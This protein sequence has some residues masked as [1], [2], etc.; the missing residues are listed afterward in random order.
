MTRSPAPPSQ[1]P[2]SGHGATGHLCGSRCPHHRAIPVGSGWGEEPLDHLGYRRDDRADR[3]PYLAALR[4]RVLIYDGGTGTELFKYQLTTA[5]YGGE[6]TNGCPEYLLIT[7]PEIM[8]AIHRR[9]F[10][11]GANVVET[12]SFGVM[13]HVLSEFGLQARAE[14][15]ATLA[16]RIARAAADEYVLPHT[17][18]FVAGAI[19]PV[20]S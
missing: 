19:G 16:A 18:R 4:D 13:P 1:P 14:E 9:Y 12:N 15:L 11:A 20:P 10:A 2:A 6:E 3:L 7:R 17:P 8:P 5:D